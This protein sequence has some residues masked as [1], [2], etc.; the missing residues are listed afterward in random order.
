MSKLNFGEK[1]IYAVTQ[2]E[3]RRISDGRVYLYERSDALRFKRTDSDI[4]IVKHA[5]LGWI[6]TDDSFEL[7]LGI[8]WPG[9]FTDSS[10]LPPEG[11]WVS[12]KDE[13]SFVYELRYVPE[14]RV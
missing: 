3:L 14:E 12:K 1:G 2:L 5:Q 7:V 10:D 6:V 9:L 11:E 8:P 13:R 4:W